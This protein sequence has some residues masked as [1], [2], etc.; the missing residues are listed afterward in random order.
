MRDNKKR[1][2]KCNELRAGGKMVIID[3]DDEYID[4]WVCTKCS[5]DA[6][7]RPVL[8]LKG[9]KFFNEIYKH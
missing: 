4:C 3:F 7:A 8:K 2:M 5:K 1:C 9:R 6:K